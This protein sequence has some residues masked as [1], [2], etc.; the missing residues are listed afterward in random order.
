[1][2]TKTWEMSDL[3]W[4]EQGDGGIILSPSTVAD[5]IYANNIE[6]ARI[7]YFDVSQAIGA[8]GWLYPC[9]LPV[10]KTILATL[11]GCVG[12]ARDKCLELLAQIAGSESAPSSPNTRNNC[13]L[14]LR[15]STWYFIYGIQFDDVELSCHYVDILFVLGIEFSAFRMNAKTY[16]ELSLTRNLPEYDIEMVKNTIAALN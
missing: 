13:L 15:L 14:E 9:A 8:K 4:S 1:M 11:P 6:Q 16:I 5:L 2:E 10:V 3:D 7:A 12:V